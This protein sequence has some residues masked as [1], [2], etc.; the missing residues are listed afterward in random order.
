M[1]AATVTLARSSSSSVIN[2]GAA[3]RL[4]DARSSPPVSGL[5]EGSGELVGLGEGVGSAI[6]TGTPLHVS[7]QP[8]AVED[9]V[10]KLRSLL[11]KNTLPPSVGAFPKKVTEVRAFPLN[12]DVPILATES[13][14]ISDE[15]LFS[16]GPRSA[17]AASPIEIT[18]FPSCNTVKEF[19]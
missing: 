13:G 5:A 19:L 4:V 6:T 10:T 16:F 12:A 18:W 1:L 15:M 11:P 8:V 9:R 17:N 2:H 7:A 3:S 14:I